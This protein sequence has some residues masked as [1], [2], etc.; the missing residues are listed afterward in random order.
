M[1][2][3]LLFILA[4]LGQMIVLT[5]FV[6]LICEMYSWSP[7]AGVLIV[8]ILELSILRFVIDQWN[9]RIFSKGSKK[10]RLCNEKVQEFIKSA[11]K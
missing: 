2:K 5:Y 8:L 3:T 7:I 4:Y 10:D 11:T 6:F 1:V 9:D